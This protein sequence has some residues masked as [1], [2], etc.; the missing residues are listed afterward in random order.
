MSRGSRG[1][2]G[3]TALVMVALMCTGLIACGDDDA[4]SSSANGLDTK[5]PGVILIGS[6]IPYVPFEFGD[7]PRYKG[8]DMDL[9][10][11][12]VKRLDVKMDVQK[13]PF[14]TVFRDLAQGRFD[15]VVSSVTITDD[16]KKLVDFSLPYFNADQSL[17]VKKGSGIKSLDDLGGK[18]VGVQIGGTGEHYVDENLDDVTKRTYDVIGD[19][20]NALAAGQVD[21][22]L[23]DFPSSKFAERQYPA[24]EVVATIPTEEQYGL[25]YPKG[26]DQLRK[27]ID[28]LL[29]ELKQDGT[30]DR[31]YQQWFE[32]DA[33]AELLQ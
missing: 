31:I 9:M 13:T 10:R 29:R 19:G 25:V 21:A 5:T 30:L 14:D 28:G 20:F 4:E 12:I 17:M 7:P 11:E 15:M 8:F 26:S 1:L 6:D 23:N 22:V 27:R 3:A 32:T 18:R 33:P 24:L 16:R 2:T